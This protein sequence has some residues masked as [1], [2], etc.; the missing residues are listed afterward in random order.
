MGIMENSGSPT[1][2]SQRW[3]CLVNC[4]FYHRFFILFTR[5]KAMNENL[6]PSKNIYF[7]FISKTTYGLFDNSGSPT[8]ISQRWISLENCNF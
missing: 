5:S 1:L 6:F 4:N 3:I 2:I 7:E 8:L